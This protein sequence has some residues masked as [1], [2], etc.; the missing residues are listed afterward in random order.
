[1]RYVSRVLKRGLFG[2]T[3]IPLGIALVFLGLVSV[4]FCFFFTGE[5][6]LWCEVLTEDIPDAYYE[7]A[8]GK[9]PMRVDAPW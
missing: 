9:E 1:M 2:L 7:W 8:T 6:W 5:A 4:P 3:I